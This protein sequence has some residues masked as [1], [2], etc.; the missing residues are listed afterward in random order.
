MEFCNRVYNFKYGLELYEI[1]ITMS[2]SFNF[3]FSLLFQ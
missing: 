2:T 1:V 3:H